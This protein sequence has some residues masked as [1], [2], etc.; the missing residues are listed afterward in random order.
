MRSTHFAIESRRRVCTASKRD[1]GGNADERGTPFENCRD[2]T[3]GFLDPHLVPKLATV[4]M[5]TSMYLPFRNISVP[6]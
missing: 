1:A 5:P 6:F 3:N 4:W 2:F